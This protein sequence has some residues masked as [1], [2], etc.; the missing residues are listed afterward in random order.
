MKLD[1]MIYDDD[2]NSLASCVL[3]NISASGAQ[4]ELERE[5]EVPQ[6]F[7]LSLSREGKVRRSCTKMWQFSTVVGVRFA[8][9]PAAQKSSA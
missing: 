8:E 5:F 9:Q 7:L 6:K 2:G 1:G 3:R 4:L